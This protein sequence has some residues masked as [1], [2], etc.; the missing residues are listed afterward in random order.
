MEEQQKKFS[1]LSDDFCRWTK[2]FGFTGLMKEFYDNTYEQGFEEDDESKTKFVEDGL[3]LP[4][5]DD[6]YLEINSNKIVANRI[7]QR[8]SN[9]F[10]FTDKA[11]Y[12]PFGF[13]VEIR[14]K[15]RHKDTRLLFKHNSQDF[16][17]MKLGVLMETYSISKKNVIEWSN[18]EDIGWLLD[19]E[20]ASCNMDPEDGEGRDYTINLKVVGRHRKSSADQANPGQLRPEFNSELSRF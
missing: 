10:I 8:D 17:Q 2:K 19:D 7:L 20:L 13:Y 5:N 15:K 9:V 12:G 11:A 3:V 1:I 18:Q 6:G 16:K 4:C 14:K